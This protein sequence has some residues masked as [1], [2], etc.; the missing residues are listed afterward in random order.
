MITLQT[1]ELKK[2]II[3]AAFFC[4]GKTTL[5][6]SNSKYTI[7]DLDEILEPKPLGDKITVTSI[8]NKEPEY[9]Q[10]IKEYYKH[11]DF[12]LLSVKP[13]LLHL[14]IKNNLPY[15]LVYPENTRECRLEWEKRNRDRNTMWIWNACKPA[16]GY[17][18]NK[19][20]KDYH[21]LKKYTLSD[22]QYLSDIIDQ[23]YMEN[24]SE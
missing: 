1:N 10:K 2:T 24:N 7:I 4:C 17:M 3:I 16:W 6:K 20:N 8:I 12:I 15:I 11:C 14:L 23:I 13:F 5:Y 22:T 9:L 19:L 18:L 21:A